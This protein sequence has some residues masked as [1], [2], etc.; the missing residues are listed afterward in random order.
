MQDTA[1]RNTVEAVSGFLRRKQVEGRFFLAGATMSLILLPLTGHAT[2]PNLGVDSDRI[3]AT[4]VIPDG[5]G[6]AVGP[7]LVAGEIIKPL[8]TRKGRPEAGQWLATH[9]ELGQSFDAYRRSIANRPE[10]RRKILYIQPIGTIP[11]DRRGL[12]DDT[13]DLL[14]RFYGLTVRTLDPID[15]AEIPEKARRKHPVYGVEQIDS[16]YVLDLLK[17]RVPGD[18]FAV[19][20]LTASD[21]WP[22]EAGRKW[23]FVFGQASLRD[24]VGVWSTC[25]LGDPRSEPAALRLRILKVAVHETGH[26]LGIEH[27]T[28]YECGMNGSNSLQES[29]R[30]PLG[31]CPE[32]EMKVW[33]ACPVDP[34]RRYEQLASFASARRLDLESSRWRAAKARLE[35]SIH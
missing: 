19:L 35:Q 21:L 10:G 34:I 30:Q 17:P 23:N 18:A 12:I 27:C 4:R 26:M 24:R 6:D 8:H 13:S 31:F 3:P 11:M 25:R 22:N 5:R 16:L 7:V 28:A 14:G 32:C 20:G 1:M 2:D 29:D 9:F 15:A 33:W